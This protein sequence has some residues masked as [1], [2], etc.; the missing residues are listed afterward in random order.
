[1]TRKKEETK[2]MPKPKKVED[3]MSMSF[4]SEPPDFEHLEIERS[5]SARNRDGKEMTF[6]HHRM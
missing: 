4:L 2:R 1:M 5:S 6:A 3:S